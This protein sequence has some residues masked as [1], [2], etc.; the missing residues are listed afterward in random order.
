MIKK[1]QKIHLRL[2]QTEKV[3]VKNVFYE[4]TMLLNSNKKF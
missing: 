2:L 1:M 3:Y 4:K